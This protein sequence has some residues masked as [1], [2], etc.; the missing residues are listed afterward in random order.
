MFP[1]KIQTS[2]KFLLYAPKNKNTFDAFE[3]NW[4]RYFDGGGR[5]ANSTLYPRHSWLFASTSLFLSPLSLSPSWPRRPPRKRPLR[6]RCEAASLRG[7]CHRPLTMIFCPSL[8]VGSSCEARSPHSYWFCCRFN[9]WSVRIQ[10]LIDFFIYGV[11]SQSRIY[12]FFSI[13]NS[14]QLHTF[15]RPPPIKSSRPFVFLFSRQTNGKEKG[16]F[17]GDWINDPW[18]AYFSLFLYHAT[19]LHTER[20][21][22]RLTE[23]GRRRGR[24][25]HYVFP[26][27]VYFVTFFLPR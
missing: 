4:S 23:D 1:I 16:G 27:F 15:S 25:F 20:A 19:L 22:A 2:T 3:M 21:R 5:P 26:F 13:E 10:H 7:L 9:G 6:P 24:C 12:S 8:S 18:G 14:R 17:Q 11:R